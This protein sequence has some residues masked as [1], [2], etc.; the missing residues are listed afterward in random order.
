MKR[1]KKKF[2]LI[3]AAFGVLAAI[4]AC[5]LFGAEHTGTAADIQTAKDGTNSPTAESSRSGSLS[6]REKENMDTEPSAKPAN[7]TAKDGSAE[8][9]NPE[10]EEER[11][12]PT[13]PED[14]TIG[15]QSQRGFLNDNTLH[16]ATGDIHYSSYIP[17]TY[18]GSEP[19]ALFIT[20]PGW[21][22]LYFQ[23][24]GANMVEDFGTE[25]LNYDDKMIVL[26]TQLNDWGET[27]A[28]QA[29]ALTEYFLEHYNI[30]PEKVYLHGMSGGGETG[31]LVM[32]KRPELYAAYLMT[33][34]Q[35]DGSLE[36]LAKAG[37]PV[38][39]AIAE[40][41]SYYGSGSLKEAYAKLHALYEKQ[42]LSEEE[43]DRLL[44]RM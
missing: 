20:L 37:T 41:D 33:S 29:I 4:C 25:A 18:D 21:E 5:L 8:E 2:F 28:D 32:G 14:I 11:Q 30:N 34:S 31:S 36:T 40:N 12:N 43:I 13:A 6:V 19:Y 17:E 39:M 15:T 24:V 1:I 27:S 23:G 22:G 26:S 42:G 7:K 9:E 38:Y 35:W 10:M 44:V 16:S 3:P